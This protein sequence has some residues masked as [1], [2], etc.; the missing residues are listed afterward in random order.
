MRVGH[1]LAIPRTWRNMGRVREIMGVLMRH[2]F[3]ELVERTGV[4]GW[5]TLP[6]SIRHRESSSK[7]RH[8]PE[9]RIRMCFEEL[10]PTYVKLGQV[11]ATRPDLI[12][13]GLVLELRKL[14]DDVPPFD[15]EAVER[16]IVEE[17]GQDLDSLFE[18]FNP[19]PLAAAS[20]AQVHRATLK[21]GEE[22]V[23]KV[24]RPDL[25]RIVGSD[26]PILKGFAGLLHEK[27]PEVQKFNIPGIISEFASALVQELDFTN[28]RYNMERF[29]QLWEDD[30]MVAAPKT[31]P[32]YCTSRVLTMEF[33][34]GV[35]A[36]DVDGLREMQ[37]E[38][39]IVSSRGTHV[40][41]R[42]I[43]EHGFFHA[44]PHP[45]NFFILPGGKVTLIDFGM[46]GV[47]DR[48]RLDE[49]LTFLVA[50]LTNDPDMMVRLFLELDIIEDTTDVRLLKRELKEL[51]QRY[52]NVNLGELDLAKFIQKI[53]DV[54][55]RHD[56]RLPADLLLVAKAITT[57]EGIAQEIDPTLDPLAEMRPYLLKTY[58]MHTLDPARHAKELAKDAGELAWLV[59]KLPGEL[60]ALL[61]KARRGQIR[62]VN[63]T[64]N[65]PEILEH[66]S[67]RTNRLVLS[68]LTTASFVSAT[69][70]HGHAENGSTVL[71][72]LGGFFALWTTLAILRSGGA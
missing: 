69:M 29:S 32:K 51:I 3:G 55:V 53:F 65:L 49:L 17:L 4:R 35:K 67:R 15:V 56:V 36:T 48:Q 31:Y 19:K 63:A 5:F 33:I 24:Q 34:D 58:M 70:L 45:G 37:V 30:P 38:P 26:L 68:I 71:W 20:I 16:Q 18:H 23:L 44:D 54:V 64:E 14:Q 40:A 13:M 39:R 50:I 59:R 2:G 66:E 42:S 7:I 62:V 27:I 57:M 12:P 11:L 25:D 72:V 47:L 60:R 41:L 8:T 6:G 52:E 43:F 21:T 46:M 28:E 22:V 9:A 10:G 61:K 1:M